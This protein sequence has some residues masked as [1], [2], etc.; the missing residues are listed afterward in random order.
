MKKLSKYTNVLPILAKGDSYTYQEIIE[1][2]NQILNE[3][4]KQKLSFFDC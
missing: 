1:I 3:S 2:K 4:I